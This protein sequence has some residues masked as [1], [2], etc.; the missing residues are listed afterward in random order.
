LCQLA[1]MRG[2]MTFLRALVERG[3]DFDVSDDGA[4]TALYVAVK[5][6][7]LPMVRFLLEQYKGRGRE[8]PDVL[9]DVAERAAKGER[10]SPILIEVARQY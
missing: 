9:R 3:A 4:F 5:Y 10:T 8:A 6:C 1:A 7:N 2:N